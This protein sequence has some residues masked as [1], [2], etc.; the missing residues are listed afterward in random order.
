MALEDLFPA[1]F[2]GYFIKILFLFHTMLL[3]FADMAIESTSYVIPYNAYSILF[4]I[5][6]LLAIVVDKNVDI[7]LVSTFLDGLC[8]IF[9]FLL[10]ILGLASG[11]WA[12]L[13]VV[14]NLII[15]PISGILLLKNYSARAGVDDPTSGLLEVNVPVASTPQARTTYQNIDKPNQSIP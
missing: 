4:L 14:V 12:I 6:L 11:F 2:D 10:L 8:I 3:V 7:V 5:C 13:L 9:D 15:R 1:L